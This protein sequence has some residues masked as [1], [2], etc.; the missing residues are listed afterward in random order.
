MKNNEIFVSKVL[1]GHMYYNSIYETCDNCGNCDGAKC[2]FC[3]TK[4]VVEDWKNDK[5]LYFGDSIEEMKEVA[6]EAGMKPEYLENSIS[7]F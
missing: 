7:W 3:K 4:Y 2:E 6:L 5:T 1:T